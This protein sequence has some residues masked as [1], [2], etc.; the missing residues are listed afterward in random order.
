MEGSALRRLVRV[1]LAVVM[2][3]VASVG[4]VSSAS[5]EPPTPTYCDTWWGSDGFNLR[6]CVGFEVGNTVVFR[7]DLKNNGPATI[8]NIRVTLTEYWRPNNLWSISTC[9]DQTTSLSG[10]QWRSFLCYMSRNAGW[11]YST[12]GTISHGSYSTYSSSPRITG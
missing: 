9:V 3:A 4:V 1:I 10:Y 5:A 2:G 7:V 12:Y 6:A 8:S 11:Q